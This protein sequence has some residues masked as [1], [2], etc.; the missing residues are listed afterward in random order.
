MPQTK[1]I[2]S[3]KYGTNPAEGLHKHLQKVIPN[4]KRSQLQKY[5]T[6]FAK[7]I[8]KP[9]KQDNPKLASN[10]FAKWIEFVKTLNKL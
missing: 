5:L 9:T 6:G 3:D 1:Y 4:Y 10:N 8:D 7:Y 2:W